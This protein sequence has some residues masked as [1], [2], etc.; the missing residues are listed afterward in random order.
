MSA[1]PTVPPKP[2]PARHAPA[3][4]SVTTI[5]TDGSRYF[6]YPADVRGR[7][8]HWRRLGAWL[9]IAV[10]LLLPWIP[11]NGAPAVFLDVA[12]R[13]FHFFGWTLAAQDAWLL[14]FGVT[15]L[16]FGLFFLTALFGRLWCGWACPQTVFLDHVYR[17]IERWLEGDAPARRAL[18]AT[19]MSAGKFFRRAAKHALYVVV[20]LAITHLFLAYF[21]SL[22]ELWSFM[23]AAPGEHWAAFLFVFTAAGVLY[24]NFA[25][26]REQLCIV[27][28]PYGRL[29]SALTDDHTV[30]IGYDSRRGEPR[31]KL[32]RDQVSCNLLGYKPPEAKPGDCIDCNRCVQVC[33]TGIDIRHGMQLECIGCAACIDACDEVMAKV[34]RPAGL[35]RYDSLAGF[36]G[37]ATRWVRPRTI[38]YGVLLA[39]GAT[40]A[41]FA[42]STVKPVSFLVYRTGGAAYFVGPDEV[43]DQFLVR[44]VNKR[45]GPATFVVSAEGLPAGLRQSGFAAPVTLAAMAESVSPLVLVADRKDYRGP[46]RFTVRVRDAAQ[47]FTLARE[48]EFM[49]PDARLLEE[50]DHEK[51]I[52]R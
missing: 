7:F 13:R 3:V 8:T 6:L 28:C 44:L 35:V 31:G 45:A 49:G 34:H 40:V 26:F 14:F 9:L 16:G 11:V 22:P 27:I 23:H 50:E 1:E 43:R 10:Y 15:G 52:K 33:P 47:T 37:G 29:Q 46:F 30:V 12:E 48:V 21:V 38:L 20:S 24:F 36:G 18:K 25:W 32:Q 2:R 39:V 42:F 5:N 19:P 41:A 51:G 4:D 17:R